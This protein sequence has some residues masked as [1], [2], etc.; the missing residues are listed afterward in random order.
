ESSH[1]TTQYYLG[2]LKEIIAIIL[3]FPA[4]KLGKLFK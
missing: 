3:E 1:D 2:I 4:E